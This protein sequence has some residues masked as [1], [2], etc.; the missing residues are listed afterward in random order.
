[1]GLRVSQLTGQR[2]DTTPMHQT[3]PSWPLTRLSMSSGRSHIHAHRPRKMTLLQRRTTPQRSVRKSSIPGRDD[4]TAM[5]SNSTDSGML[6]SR[7]MS[8]REGKVT[9]R[10]SFTDQIV[11]MDAVDYRSANTGII[12]ICGWIGIGICPDSEALVRN[13]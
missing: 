2:S 8:L 5:A 12:V 6:S 11:I 3:P 13:L 4:T 1:M 7:R 10:K 9:T